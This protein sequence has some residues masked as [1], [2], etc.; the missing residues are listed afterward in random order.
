MRTKVESIVPAR[1][2][3]LDIISNN[4]LFVISKGEQTGRRANY[5]LA[6][7]ISVSLG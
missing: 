7:G 2:Y 6:C 4:S 5:A 3:G 1:R